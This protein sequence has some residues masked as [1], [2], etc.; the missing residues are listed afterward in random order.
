MY[1]A[2]EGERVNAC[3]ALNAAIDRTVAV[4][5]ITLDMTASG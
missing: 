2:T 4:S 5:A 3:I 1:E